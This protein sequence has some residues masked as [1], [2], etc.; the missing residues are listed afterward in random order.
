MPAFLP[1]T[2]HLIRCSC[3]C[4]WSV[5]A[6]AERPGVSQAEKGASRVAGDAAA[7]P[8]TA[9]AGALPCASGGGNTQLLRHGSTASRAGSTCVIGPRIQAIRAQWPLFSRHA[10]RPRAWADGS[11]IAPT[12]DTTTDGMPC[13]HK[14]REHRQ[15]TADQRGQTSE[16]ADVA[17][18]RE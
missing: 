10:A 2:T 11:R 13:R 12:V 18:L 3:Q 6:Q 14:R 9:A 15:V 4:C 1:P 5:H 17:R 8:A 16:Q 7:A